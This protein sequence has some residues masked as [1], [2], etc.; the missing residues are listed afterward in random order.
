MVSIKLTDVEMKY[1]YLLE[2]ITGVT[3]MDCVIDE[4]NNRII[5]L[6]KKGQ[7]GI[8]VGRN[9]INIK[10]LQ[11]LIGKNVEIV[12]YAETLE[13]LIKNSLFPARVLS[14]R[15]KKDANNRKIV[16]VSVPANEKGLAIG[17]DGKN[18]KRAR[19]LAKRYFNIDWVT[20]E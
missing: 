2:S 3:T 15:L 13:E 9:G 12:E 6:V 10:R 1:I 18:I 14:V 16:V 4:E 7:V 11:K 20:L 5:F 8:A 17:K 19:I